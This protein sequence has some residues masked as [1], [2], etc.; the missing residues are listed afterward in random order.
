[1]V[2]EAQAVQV[3]QKT[4]AE[5]ILQH[6]QLSHQQVVVEVLEEILTA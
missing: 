3:Q 2:Q 5:V 1:M 4:A 6:S